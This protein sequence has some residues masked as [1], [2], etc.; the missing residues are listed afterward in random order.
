MSRS[1]VDASVV[2]ALLN[3][4]AGADEASEILAEGAFLGA[5]NLAEVV[6]RLADAGH[7]EA[8]IRGVLGRLNLEVAPFDETDAWRSGLLRE[9]TRVRGLALGDRA[10]LALAERLRLPAVTADRAWKGLPV[11]ATIRVL[12]R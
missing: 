12:G 6:G 3:G 8:E 1:V 11:E 10:C 5:V 4:E 9:A 7:S 2:L